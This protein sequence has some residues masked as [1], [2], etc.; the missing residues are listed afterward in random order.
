VT[1]HGNPRLRHLLVEAAWRMLQWQPEY[2][3]IRKARGLTGRARKRAIV[4]AARQLAVDLWRLRTG[5]S[6]PEKLQL[7]MMK[8]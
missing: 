4:A 2:P 1:K 7:V 3:P 6:T 5:R 8:L